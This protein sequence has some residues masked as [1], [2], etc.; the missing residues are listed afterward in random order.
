MNNANTP[1]RLAK[2]QTAFAGHIRNPEGVPAPAGI[3]ER[4]MNVYR[5]LFFNNIKRL[6]A[7]NFP[8]LHRLYGEANWSR[9]VREFYIEHRAQT[10]LFPELAREFLRYVQDQRHQ[11]PGDPP[12][13]LELAHYEWV[14]LALSLDQ[15]DLQT[16]PAN[17]D[18]NLLEGIPVLSPLAWPLSYGFPVHRITP[19]FQPKEAPA[20]PTHL[21]VYRNRADQVKFMQLND[22]TRLFLALLQERADLTGRR[23]LELTAAQIG[24]Q[25]PPS[26]IESGAILMQDLSGRD[27]LLGTRLDARTC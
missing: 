17:P 5:E 3:E 27:V 2:L 16:I 4:R 10:P 1:E 22:V 18:G 21:L 20:E 19:A 6:L 14:E 9:L 13:L 12:F 26:V 23:L 7:G 8:V 11:R 15:L 25:S 24:H